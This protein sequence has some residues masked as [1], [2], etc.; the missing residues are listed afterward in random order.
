M[1]PLMTSSQCI[2]VN[3]TWYPP[4]SC[5]TSVSEN[6]AAP[7]FLLMVGRHRRW[8]ATTT[9][10]LGHMFLL[11]SFQDWHTQLRPPQWFIPDVGKLYV[12]CNKKNKRIMCDCYFKWGHNNMRLLCLEIDNNVRLLCLV[13]DNNVWLLCLVRSLKFV[14]VIFSER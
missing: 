12:V 7:V 8:W 9:S 3:Y 1:W 11:W 4:I 10:T 2:T 14:I 5:C 13:R 6:D